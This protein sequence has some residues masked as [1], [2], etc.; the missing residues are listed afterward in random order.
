MEY[1][2][3]SMETFRLYFKCNGEPSE[4]CNRGRMGPDFDF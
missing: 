2:S 3:F 1:F 4:D